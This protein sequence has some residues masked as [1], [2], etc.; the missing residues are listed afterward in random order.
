[1]PDPLHCP[2]PFVITASPAKTWSGGAGFQDLG[3]QG[4]K[5]GGSGDL[6]SRWDL[7]LVFLPCRILGPGGTFRG[8]SPYPIT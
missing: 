3:F 5:K 7:F 1:M 6:V 4:L 8:P 2:H